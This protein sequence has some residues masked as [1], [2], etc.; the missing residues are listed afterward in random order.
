MKD[1]QI[2][3]LNQ[4]A[5]NYTQ[6]APSQVI[7]HIAASYQLVLPR[8]LLRYY[9]QDSDGVRIVEEMIQSAIDDIYYLALRDPIEGIIRASCWSRKE[10]SSSGGY[11]P[12]AG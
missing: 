7:G 6:G 3:G 10:K 12:P 5:K 8:P 2:R 9:V 1:Y 11:H 4:W